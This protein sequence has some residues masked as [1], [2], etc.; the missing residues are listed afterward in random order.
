MNIGIIPSRLKSSRLPNK[1]IKKIEGLEIIN[2]VYQRSVLSGILD[3]IYVATCDK[4]ILKVVKK[5]NGNVIMTSKKH[6]NAIDRSYEAINKVLFKNKII[7]KNKINIIIIQGDE[8]TLEPNLI[9]LIAKNL[10]KNCIV[11]I[12]SLLKKKKDINDPNRVKVTLDK[13]SNAVYF[14]RAPIVNCLNNKKIFLKQGNLFG[15]KYK[16]LKQFVNYKR[17]NLEKVESIDMLRLIENNIKI[18]MVH[19]M[20]KTV[21]VDTIKDYFYAKKFFKSDK[22]KYKYL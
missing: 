6:T 22:L 5:V 12:Y 1:A 3:K 13:N 19:A 2:H 7:N 17:T 20:Y 4:E 10:K 21:N 16:S 9:G 18:K 8:P 14:S 11:N 15:F